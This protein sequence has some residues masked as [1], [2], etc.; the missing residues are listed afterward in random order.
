MLG[1]ISLDLFAVLLGGAVALLP[2]YARDILE[3]GPWGLGL[4]RSAPAI[5]AITVAILLHRFPIRDNAG[6]ILFVCVG[7]FGAFTVVFGFSTAVWLSIAA[8]FFMGATDMV[9]VVLRETLMQLW[10]PDEVRGRVSAVNSVFIGAS[11]ELGE[12][13]AGFV[14]AK[15]GTVFAVVFGG[16]GTMAVASLWSVMF[17]GLRKQRRIDKRMA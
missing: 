2:V 8:L 1:A 13:R 3:V 9:S 11:N 16:F 5:G 10:T 12:F 6:I 14:A 17:P 15:W 4:L 7:L